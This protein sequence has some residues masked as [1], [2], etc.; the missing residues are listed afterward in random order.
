VI[1]VKDGDK[2]VEWKAETNSPSVLARRGWA[3]DSLTIGETVT[4]VG[5][6]ARNDAN[7]MR[8]LSV[9]RSNGESVGASLSASEQQK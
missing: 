8:V 7:L 3:R 1:T 4:L 2:E 6:P 5:W 9:T